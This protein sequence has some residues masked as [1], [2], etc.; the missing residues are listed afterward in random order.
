MT[1]WRSRELQ[2][3]SK[4]GKYTTTQ[5]TWPIWGL[6]R[7][8]DWRS[9]KPDLTR[10]S[11]TT[12]HQRCVLRR[13]WSWIREKNCS[14]KSMNLLVHRRESYWNRP[15][16]MDARRLQALRREH[17]TPILD[18]AGRPPAAKSAIGFKGYPIIQFNKKITHSRKQSKSW[19]IN[20]KRIQIERRWTPTWG[21]I[22]RTTHS[23]KIRRTLSAAWETW[24]TLRCVKYLIEFSSS[25]FDILDERHCMLYLRDLLVSYRQIAQIKQGS[26]WCIIGSLMHYRFQ[27][28]W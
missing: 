2:C 9:I 13:R 1:T 26:I 4:I 15:C 5:C 7:R 23:A 18:S 19:F 16:T 3:S 25:L 11:F 20:R 6:L 27:T 12:L 14:T 24:S 8:R 22:T 17:P 28:T 10:S 21:K